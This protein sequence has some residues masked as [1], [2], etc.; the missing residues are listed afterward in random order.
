MAM[1]A[2]M[3]LS[4]VL[5]F[6]LEKFAGGAK[7]ASTQQLSTMSGGQSNLLEQLLS[8]LGG[9]LSQGVGNASNLLSND[10]NAI[11]AFQ[12]PAITQFKQ[13]I[14]PGI[15]ERFSGLNAQSSSAFKNALGGA[16]ATLTEN[17]NAQRAQLQQGAFDQIL[18]LL[19]VGLGSK[20]FENIAR[21]AQ[22]SPYAGL[23]GEIGKGATS[24]GFDWLRKK[25]DLPMA[26]STD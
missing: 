24:M 19:G 8:M 11:A 9:P 14:I 2:A 23:A 5:P 1:P 22:D 13:S 16:G 15:A 18:K 12:Q 3:V 10:P 25:N 17:L 7:D 6:L 4:S 21:P 20:P 26:K